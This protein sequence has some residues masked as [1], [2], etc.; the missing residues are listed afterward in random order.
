[1]SIICRHIFRNIKS[2]KGRSLL[3]IISLIVA[4][5]V[6]ILNVTLGDEIANKYEQTLKSV[7]GESDVGIT[8]KEGKN[9]TDMLAKELVL[10]KLNLGNTELDTLLISNVEGFAKINGEGK[11]TMIKGMD[12]QDA[13]RMDEFCKN[14]IELTD[15]QLVVNGKCSE[16]YNIHKGDT[17]T[18]TYGDKDYKMEVVE[19]VANYRLTSIEEDYPYFISNLTT[20]NKMLEYGEGSGLELYVDVKDNEKIKEFV[21]YFKAHNQTISCEELVN[22][23]SLEDAITSITSM[24]TII[25]VIVIIMIFFVVGSLNKLVIAERVPVIGTFRSVGATKRR[26]NLILIGENVVYGLIGGIIGSAAG[27]V[28]NTM[29]AKTFITTKGVELSTDKA[30]IKWGVYLGG[31]LFAIL[32]EVVISLKTILRAN[33]KPIKEIIFNV[34]STRYKINKKKSYFGLGLIMI[35]LIL[36]LTNSDSMFMTSLV[37]MAI[38]MIGCA[39]LVPV[40]LRFIS[41]GSTILLRKMGWSS[42]VLASRNI[43]Y[44]KTIISSSTLMVVAIAS[45]LTI[46]NVSVTFTK[47]FESFRYNNDFDV[48]VGNVSQEYDKYSFIKDMDGVTATKPMYYMF[49]NQVTYG[50]NKSFSIPPSFLI[51]EKDNMQGILLDDP[52]FD[53]DTLKDNEI[54]VDSFFAKRNHINI[55]DTLTLTVNER[56]L[57][58]E[59]TVV[60]TTNSAKM[61]SQRNIFAMNRATYLKNFTTIPLMIQVYLKDGVDPEKFIEQL[62]GEIKEFNVYFKSFEQYIDEQEQQT[63]GVM[64]VFYVIIGL[65]VGLSFVGIVNNQIIGFIQ[66]KRE[67][68]VLNSTCMSKGQIMKM[69]FTETLL[70][71]IISGLIACIVVIPSVY[72]VNT[73]MEGISLHLNI[74]YNLMASIGFVGIVVLI[75]LLTTLNPLHRIR[76]MNIVE[77]IKYE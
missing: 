35:A 33:R 49:S 16:K 75:L 26:M 57:E 77:E 28:L 15:N 58:G 63:A 27:Y 40:W 12:L 64:N 21:S 9:L 66:R 55:G 69:L 19:V 1:M 5:A 29:V 37:A 23:E 60:G 30:G 42:G 59:L 45:I 54:L 71:S 32:L 67:I 73:A 38:L 51:I 31:I 74:G 20:A 6:L 4:T 70:T 8:I 36:Q 13:Y 18:F 34:Q 56:N 24:L 2:H 76:K 3:V 17:I 43:G 22:R 41:K 52:S 44:N 11:P 48:V 47:I 46:F 14:S 39:F 7:Y 65:A 61:N 62:K 50:E 68:A 10:D 72:M 25:L 53:V